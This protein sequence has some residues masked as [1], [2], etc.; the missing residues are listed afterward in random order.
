MFKPTYLYIKTHND[1]GIKYF[2]KTIKPD[3][4]KYKGSG[5]KWLNHIKKH[6][7][8]VTTEI[9]GFYESEFECSEAAIKFSKDNLIVESE[10]WANQIIETGTDESLEQ[11]LPSSIVK[12][13]KTCLEK[14]GDDY[15]AKIASTSK[16][17]DHKENIRK[18]VLESIKLGASGKK[19]IGKIRETVECPNCGKHGAKNTMV[20]WHFD[21]CKQKR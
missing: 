20:R 1:T 16:S 10:I 19:N 6:G 9:L 3:P 2:G 18:S 13:T 12:R 14:Y 17:D 11:L 15:F 8:N 21:N 7:N 4:V 5:S